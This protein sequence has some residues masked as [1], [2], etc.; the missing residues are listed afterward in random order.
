MTKNNL[1]LYLI[2]FVSGFGIAYFVIPTKTVVQKVEVSSEADKKT[3]ADLNLQINTLEKINKT[4]KER[5][6][7]ITITSPDGS[8]TEETIRDTDTSEQKEI[9]IKAVYEAKIET[10]EKEISELKSKTVTDI[11]KKSF[12]VELGY[13]VSQSMY[14]HSTYDLFGSIFVGGH[15]VIGKNNSIGA[16]IGLRL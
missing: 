6:R 2:I 10:L 3:I 1:I 16:G 12:G 14:I 13:D 11:N 8:K 4:I 15:A 5:V 9:E 7:T